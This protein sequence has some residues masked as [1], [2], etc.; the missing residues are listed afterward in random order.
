[1]HLTLSFKSGYGSILERMKYKDTNEIGDQIFYVNKEYFL[2]EDA[3][4][5]SL[6]TSKH[7][8][9][10]PSAFGAVHGIGSSAT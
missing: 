6:K 10:R 4:R 5:N 1:M 2:L 8:S 7:P 3:T 9:S